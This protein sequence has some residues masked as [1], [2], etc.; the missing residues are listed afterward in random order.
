[1]SGRLPSYSARDGPSFSILNLYG[2]YIET[3]N[4]LPQGTSIFV[5]ISA[6]KAG[7]QARAESSTQNPI[8]VLASSSK[9]L[10][11]VI[12]PFLKSGCWKL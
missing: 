3:A 9:A 10:S 1:V 8:R 11:R 2:C 6:G 7:F 5:K 4:P 12:N